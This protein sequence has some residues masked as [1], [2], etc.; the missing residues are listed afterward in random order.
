M[1]GEFEELV[2][3]SSMYYPMGYETAEEIDRALA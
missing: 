3:F 1:R 2:C